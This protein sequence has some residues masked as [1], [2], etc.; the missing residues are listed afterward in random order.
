MRNAVLVSL[1]L[2]KYILTHTA[3]IEMYVK[4]DGVMECVNGR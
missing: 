2:M 3:D 1:C 4:G